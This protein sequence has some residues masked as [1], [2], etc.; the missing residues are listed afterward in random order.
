MTLREELEL[1]KNN[2][3]TTNANT[4][5]VRMEKCVRDA[6]LVARR[7]NLVIRGLRE[8]AG[9]TKGEILTIVKAILTD[10]GVFGNDPTLVARS[11]KILPN[12]IRV[13]NLKFDTPLKRDVIFNARFALR[14]IDRY[15]GVYIDSDDP[16]FVQHERFLQREERR[17]TGTVTQVRGPN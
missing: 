17:K 6:E 11:G 8:R 2:P 10:I 16:P 3:S 1:L 13:V 4:D 7:N 12:K 9:E 15:A 5:L 14:S